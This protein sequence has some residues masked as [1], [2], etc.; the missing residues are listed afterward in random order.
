[1]TSDII[2]VG[3]GLVGPL[4]A[5]MLRKRGHTVRIYERG[6]DPR[7]IT[8]A[9]GRS[10]NLVLTTRGL[11]GARRVGLK[12]IDDLCVPVKG[13][14]MHL[15]DGRQVFQPYGHEN[16]WNN[17]VSRWYVG[18]YLKTRFFVC[19]FGWLFFTFVFLR[20]HY[21]QNQ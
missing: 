12:G 20:F 1:M 11:R 2:V 18:S 16:E 8:D 9:G 21:L 13:R 10:I 5:I 6:L 7:S 3:G 17:S 14:M 4:L 19:L 15:A